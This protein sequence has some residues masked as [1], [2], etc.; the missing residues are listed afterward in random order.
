MDKFG[1][2]PTEHALAD[3]PGLLAIGGDLSTERLIH[4]Y[5]KGI[6]PWYSEGEPILWWTPEPRCVLFPNDFVLSKS[7]KKRSRKNYRL[8]LNAAF[9]KVIEYCATV[10]KRRG[11]TWILPELIQAYSA[12]H[13]LGYAHSLEVWLDEELIGGLYGIKLGRVF[14]G[15]SMFSRSTDGSKLALAALSRV[16]RNSGVTLIDCQVENPHLLSLGACLLSRLDF[17]N[18]LRDNVHATID[19][20]VW[21]V[22][23]QTKD[24]V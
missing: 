23:G 12:L 13:T 2:P 17:E 9:G 21:R 10:D 22:P 7:L 4:A 11:H 5:S 14:F 6:F 15:E 3:P 8:S 19:Q 24:L 1:F 18:I 16:C 20:N